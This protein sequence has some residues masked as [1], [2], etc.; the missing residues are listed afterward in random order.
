VENLFFIQDAV[1][2]GEGGGEATGSQAAT[3][4]AQSSQIQTTLLS[5]N[6]LKKRQAENQHQLQQHMSEL[7]SYTSTKF[8]QVHTNMNRF[9]ASPARRIGQ[10]RPGASDASV[11]H[12]LNKTY[13]FTA[14][15]SSC[16]RKLVLIWQEY[17]YGLEGNKAAKNFTSVE[18][19]R[20]K[21]KFCC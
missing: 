20:V 7:R 13:D 12:T 1:T 6:W 21:F 19:G 16:P 4:A 5:I 2:M 15:I 18:R 9:S 3:A 17:F 11:C 8:K 14:N 10:T